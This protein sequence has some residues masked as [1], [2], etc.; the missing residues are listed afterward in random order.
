MRKDVNLGTS[1]STTNSRSL[2]VHL[3]RVVVTVFLTDIALVF[4][5]CLAA[6]PGEPVNVV[7]FGQLK[8]WDSQQKDYGVLWEDPRVIF[9]VMVKF[10]DAKA[11][12]NPK[13]VRLEYWQS[14]WPRHRIPRDSPSGAGS[15]GWLNVGDWFQGK[16]L[17][18]DA[19]LDVEGVIYAFTFNPLN[20]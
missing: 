15:S 6:Q 8:I 17:K 16:W 20:S 7:P 11:V 3:Q 10:A 14:S 4:G 1:G 18:A 2:K 13:A 5:F 12:P 19:D 9:R